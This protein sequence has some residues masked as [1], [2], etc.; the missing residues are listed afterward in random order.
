MFITRVII[1]CP[2]LQAF[3]LEID[4]RG[5]QMSINEKV[6]GQSPVYV[7]IS[8][9]ALGG[10]GGMLLQKILD[11]RLRLSLVHSQGLCIE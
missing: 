6:G 10:S 5:G 4:P 9:C 3:I 11:L 1:A 7:C 8:T 2:S